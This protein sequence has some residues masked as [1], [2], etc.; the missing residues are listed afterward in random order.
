MFI[1]YYVYYVYIM[2]MFY[3]VYFVNEEQKQGVVKPGFASRTLRNN[4]ELAH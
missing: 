4:C 1:L 3:Y 2:F